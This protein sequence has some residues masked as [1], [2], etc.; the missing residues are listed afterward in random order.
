MGS[1]SISLANDTNAFSLSAFY[2]SPSERKEPT[3]ADCGFTESAQISSDSYD[4]IAEH[5]ERTK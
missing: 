1:F 5:P 3:A 2:E 4:L